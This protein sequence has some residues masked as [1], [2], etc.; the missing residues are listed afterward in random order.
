MG[1][2]QHSFLHLGGD[3]RAFGL[4]FVP[5]R[6]EMLTAL[7]RQDCDL[8]HERLNQAKWHRKEFKVWT[9]LQERLYDAGGTY[10]PLPP[11]PFDF[12]N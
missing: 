6:C 10:L 2:V 1:G 4:G 3:K 7:S 11:D 5:H 9:S 12:V 8:S